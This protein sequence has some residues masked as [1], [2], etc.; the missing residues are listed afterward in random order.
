MRYYRDDPQICVNLAFLLLQPSMSMTVRHLPRTRHL[1]CLEH[2]SQKGCSDSSVLT[3]CRLLKFGLVMQELM[4]ESHG[5]TAY[6]A[7]HRPQ[8]L[9]MLTDCRMDSKDDLPPTPQTSFWSSILVC[10]RLQACKRCAGLQ[11]TIFLVTGLCHVTN[12][13]SRLK[14]NF[15]LQ[16]HATVPADEPE[17][18]PIIQ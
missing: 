5:L 4:K 6:L 10:S 11:S 8:V 12:C 18:D 13:Q 16:D 1:C 17:M 15:S 14:N 7:I 3:S 9:Y 2:L